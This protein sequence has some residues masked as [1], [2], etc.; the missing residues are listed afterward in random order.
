MAQPQDIMTR[1]IR[2]ALIGFCILMAAFV[3]SGVLWA[4]A[5]GENPVIGAFLGMLAVVALA[6]LAWIAVGLES[7]RRELLRRRSDHASA[8]Q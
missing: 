2:A 7:A 3:T 8:G 5:A 4:L 1:R 6:G